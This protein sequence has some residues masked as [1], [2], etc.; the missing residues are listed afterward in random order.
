MTILKRKTAFSIAALAF[1]TSLEACAYP[2]PYRPARSAAKAVEYSALG[3]EA[4]V[5]R[6]IKPATPPISTTFESRLFL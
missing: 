3:W 4:G 1:A 6:G 5:Q 2:A